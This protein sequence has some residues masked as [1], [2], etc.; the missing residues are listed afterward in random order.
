MKTESFNEN[1]FMIS[2][3]VM[4]AYWFCP[5][6]LYFMECQFLSQNENDRYKVKVG[7]E[8]HKKK[9]TAPNYLRK[10]LKAVKQEREVYLGDSDLGICGIIDDLLTLED[11]SM[12]LID[13]KFAKKKARFNTHFSQLVFYSLLIEK[14]YQAKVN[15]GFVVYTRSGTKLEPFEITEKDK[16]RVIKNIDEVRKIKA[17][18]F[19]P[20]GNPSVLKCSDCAFSKVCIM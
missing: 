1:S 18:G 20:S 16:K 17:E 2:A 9:A 12:T 8:I 6:F 14:N 13:Y 4:L 15:K 19:F 5:R 11:G 7:R 3:T 10:S